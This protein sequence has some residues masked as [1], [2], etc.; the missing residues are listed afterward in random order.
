MQVNWQTFHKIN[1]LVLEK[2]TNRPPADKE[3]MLTPVEISEI[4]E[5]LARA[6]ADLAAVHG[7]LD[8]TWER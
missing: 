4:N 6:Y 5:R 7:L 8:E 2:R 1:V 3:E